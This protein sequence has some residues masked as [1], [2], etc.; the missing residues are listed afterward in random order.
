MGKV[1]DIF[2]KACGGKSI[3]NLCLLLGIFLPIAGVSA[4][5][6][7]CYFR[8]TEHEL[9]LGNSVVEIRLHP[10]SGVVTGLY[11]KTRSIEYLNPSVPELFNLIYSSTEYHGTPANDPWSAVDGTTVKGSAQQIA[12]KHFE[13]TAEGAR[14]TLHYDRLRLEKRNIDVGVTVSI[15]LRDNDA[16]TIWKI[17][18]QNNDAGVVKEIQFPMLNGLNRFQTLI[19]PNE[20]GQKI[21][22]PID[23]LS[24]E[25][26]VVWL[27]YP[28][29]GSMQW[30][31]YYS[32]EAGL[33]MA[34]Y[35]QELHYTRMCFG[36]LG[37]GPE[38]G[39]WFVNY[40][41]AARGITWKS[42]ALAV[43]LHTGDWHCGADRYRVWLESWIKRAEVPLTVREMIGG[44]REMGIKNRNGSVIHSYD[45][46]PVLAAQVARSPRGGPFMVAGWMYNGHDT[47][48]PEYR[49][50][51]DMGGDERLKAAIAEVHRQGATLTAYVNGRLASVDA[52]TYRSNGKGWSVLGKA[53]GL[54]VNTVDF[55]ELHEAWNQ[56]WDSTQSALGWH[57]VMC[58][59]V[60]EWQDHIVGEVRRVIGE[61]GFDGIFFDQ[62]GS[63]YAELCYNKRHGHS[64]P[65]TAWGPG[66]LEMFRRVREEM[67]R[68]NPES[69]LWTE[70]MNDAFGQYMDYGMD[71]N[72]LWQPM[73]IHPKCKTF[74]E[75]WRYTLPDYI[76][77]N[78]PGTYSFPPS[79]DPVHG[80][81][82]NFVLG[83][84]GI[85]PSP[86]RDIEQDN[87]NDPDGAQR[88]EVVARIERLSIA[89]SDYLFHGRFMDNVGLDIPDTAI[90][91]KVY[92]S[93]SGL[94]VPI[95]N[96]RHEAISTEIKI[97]LNKLGIVSDRRLS[98]RSLDTS[99][100]IPH[101]IDDG[102][103]TIPLTLQGQG[104]DVVVVER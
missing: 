4:S 67:R 46:M 86:E 102:V 18:V 19:M 25:L 8:E 54:G 16:E 60:H 2:K 6:D 91:A 84:R 53:S 70:G 23:M 78:D 1:T 44:L 52:D 68:I 59:F 62:P 73:R 45:E 40:P 34:S 41:F 98:V 32:N 66:Y 10:G 71:K 76:I 21:T 57:A 94:A 81:K 7:E 72:P 104:L 14:L 100:R 80:L 48:Y 63:Y 33:Y 9:L 64:N 17:G 51:P 74:V 50:I 83:V 79:K 27:E 47:Y 38:A 42:P 87:A 95:W 89:A 99:R 49:A 92:K 88:R 82:Y 15:E 35:N 30:F 20:S 31:D 69:V 65:A 55:F 37:Q 58:P 5:S 103:L 22:D 93:V 39:M 13:K 96:T 77:V 56:D 90:L 97:E 24:D 75:M 28:G 43:C 101:R 3:R 26:P 61:Y 85:F 36:R 12:R 11:N 29:R